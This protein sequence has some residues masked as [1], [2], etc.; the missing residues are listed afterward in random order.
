MHGFLRIT[1]PF[2]HRINSPSDWAAAPQTNVFYCVLNVC[3]TANLLLLG[4]KTDNTSERFLLSLFSL[5][6][7][8]F[9]NLHPQMIIFMIKSVIF[10][11][12]LH[13]FKNYIFYFEKAENRR[14]TLAA[15]YNHTEE[16]AAVFSARNNIENKVK[17]F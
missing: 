5:P 6:H 2:F 17:E 16:R 9:N 15:S 8:L 11:D 12:N 13:I 3:L 10:A 4:V 14:I 1:F 7:S